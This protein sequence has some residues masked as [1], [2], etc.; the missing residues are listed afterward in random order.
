MV[1]VV[2]IFTTDSE[3]EKTKAAMKYVI[4]EY[5]CLEGPKRGYVITEST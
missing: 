1:T 2:M 4:N 3:R 5:I